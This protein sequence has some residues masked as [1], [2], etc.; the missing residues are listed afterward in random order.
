MSSLYMEDG[1]RSDWGKVYVALR[2]GEEVHIR[3][4]T[5]EEL[6]LANEQLERINKWMKG[7]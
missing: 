6:K 3:Q 1:S 2:N 5:D 7:E 4:A